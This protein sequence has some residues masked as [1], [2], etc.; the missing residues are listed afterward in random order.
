M[1]KVLFILF[2]GINIFSMFLGNYVDKHYL[3]EWID[4]KPFNCRLCCS[5]H[6]AW[7]MHTFVAIIA[8]SWLYF[9][10]GICAA[11]TIYYL[12]YM[13]EKAQWE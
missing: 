4:F 2:V 6:S 7:I 9:I 11:A 1:I 3:P 8:N 13:D 5:T 10:L 12:I